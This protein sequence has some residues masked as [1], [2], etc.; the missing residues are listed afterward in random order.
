M[1]K[2]LIVRMGAMG[3]IIH[4]LP[5]VA[6]LRVRYPRAH[7]GWVI[8]RR[9]SDLLWAQGASTEASLSAEKP[10]INELFEV[11]TKGWRRA[12]LAPETRKALGSILRDIRAHDFDVTIDLQGSLKSALAA[13]ASHAIRVIGPAKPREFPARWFYS[14]TVETTQAHVVEQY[15]ELVTPVLGASQKPSR[16]TNLLPTDR[17]AE[18]WLEKEIVSR[19]LKSWRYAVLSAGAGWRAKEWPAERY[20][21]LA[22]HLAKEGIRSL[23]NVGP[24][25]TRLAE[26]VEQASGGHAQAIRCNISQL[27]ALLRR[28]TLFVGGDTGPMHMANLLG[29]PVVALFGPTDPERNGPYFQP[30]TVLRNAASATSYSH[31]N[32]QD[33]GLPQITV[34]QVLDAARELLVQA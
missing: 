19:G 20:G 8:E 24:S 29:V 18:H 11:D 21:E 32:T 1:E 12:L 4:G 5:A 33:A 13:R 30:S 17:S 10:L 22:R 28:A 9:W 26:T 23:V 34:E 6:L 14:Q 3:D 7:I 15:T 27:I 31:T 16:D 25:E 2:I